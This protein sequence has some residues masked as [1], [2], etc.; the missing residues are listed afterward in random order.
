LPFRDSLSDLDLITFEACPYSNIVSSLNLR[1]NQ[2]IFWCMPSLQKPHIAMA[3][4]V[5]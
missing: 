1:I 2:G 4:P 5:S 3:M